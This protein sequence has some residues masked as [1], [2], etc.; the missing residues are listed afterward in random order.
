MSTK[1]KNIKKVLMET[2]KGFDIFYDK[3]KERLVADKPKL[4]IHF[5]ARSI[6]EIKGYIRDSKTEEVNKEGLVKHGY[7]GR[8]IAKIRIMT[9]NKET[10]RYEYEVL[11]ITDNGYDVGKI[12]NDGGIPQIYELTEHNM[13]IYDE[14]RKLE[15][16]IKGIENEQVNK[17]KQLKLWQRIQSR[18]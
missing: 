9:V 1:K 4:N 13:K 3:E 14:V 2:F 11:A 6:W 12:M 7:F 8:E 15:K 16:D 10:K 18:T 17:V 5:E